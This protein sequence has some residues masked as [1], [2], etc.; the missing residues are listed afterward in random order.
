MFESFLTIVREQGLRVPSDY[1]VLLTTL[2][3]LQGVAKHMAP[4]YRL[5]DT[6]AAYARSAVG[7]RLSPEQL[8]TGAHRTL[9]RYKHLLDDLPVG[10]SRALRRASEGEFR[11]AV[12]PSDYDR[13]LD[14][15]RDLV[16]PV[17]L[18]VLLAAFVVGSSV[19]VALQPGSTTA[20]VGGAMLATVTAVTVLWMITLLVGYRRRR[21]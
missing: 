13:L 2:A 4:D 10:L 15:L 14:R 18:T 12:R 9:A 21:R 5:T 3:M 1:V 6:V 7:G 19:I 8:V 16:I 17:C 20:G 11:V